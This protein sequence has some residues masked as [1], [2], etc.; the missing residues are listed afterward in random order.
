MPSRARSAMPPPVPSTLRGAWPARTT[1]P[2]PPTTTS[3]APP[4]GVADSKHPVRALAGSVALLLVAA[5]AAWADV[6]TPDPV[7]GGARPALLGGDPAALAP[8]ELT[9]TTTSTTTTSTTTTTAPPPPPTTT[10][11]PPVAAAAAPTPAPPPVPASLEPY[12]GLGTWVDVY[13]WSNSYTGG[14]PAVGP[15]DVD[16]MAD[17]GVQTLY[18]QASKWDSPGDLVDPELLHPILERAEQ[19]GIRVVTWY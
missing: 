18:L 15:A 12:R 19:R 14:K 4:G 13:D 9:T 1:S 3:S 5:A 16:R 6:R 17:T 7:G 11:P 8:A 2:L 10:P